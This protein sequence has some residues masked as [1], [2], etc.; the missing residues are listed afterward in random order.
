ML[1]VALACLILTLCSWEASG[2]DLNYG[3]SHATH[4]ADGSLITGV[5]SYVIR[6]SIDN[7]EQPIVNVGDVESY[8]L[9]NIISGVYSAQVATIEDG[10]QGE[11]SPVITTTVNK[12]QAAEPNSVTITVTL[13][14]VDCGLEVQ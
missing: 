5:R 4:R 9:T 14:C 12:V 1:K 7:I 11:W 2:A 13:D 6:Y 10:L 8:T 3:W